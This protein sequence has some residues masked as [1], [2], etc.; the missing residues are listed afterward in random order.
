MLYSKKNICSFFLAGAALPRAP[1]CELL[2]FYG[3]EG[4]FLR[5]V[6][7]PVD[8]IATFTGTRSPVPYKFRYMTSRGERV[9]VRVDRVARTEKTRLA[10]RTG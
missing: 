10:G 8:M 6:D 1:H 3:K 4:V 9:E 5:I 7:L 2:V